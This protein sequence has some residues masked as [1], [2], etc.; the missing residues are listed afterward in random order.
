MSTSLHLPDRLELGGTEKDGTPYHM[1]TELMVV[2]CPRCYK[3]TQST[4]MYDG[5]VLYDH[6]TS[7]CELVDHI[8]EMAP[9]EFMD[10]WMRYYHYVN[11]D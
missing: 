1:V 2:R 3:E 4:C 7:Q 5:K 10:S 11:L 8:G 9:Q 6:G